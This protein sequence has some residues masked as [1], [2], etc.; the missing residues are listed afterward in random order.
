MQLACKPAAS[1]L[2][3]CFQYMEDPSTS[4]FGALICQGAR[5]TEED[6]QKVLTSEPQAKC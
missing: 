5:E 6:Q 4:K 1:N 2:I 3:G